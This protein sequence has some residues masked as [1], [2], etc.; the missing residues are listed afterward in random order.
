MLA[1]RGE[2]TERPSVWFS[3]VT[4][5]RLLLCTAWC[6]IRAAATI[7]AHTPHRMTLAIVILLCARAAMLLGMCAWHRSWCVGQGWAWIRDGSGRIKIWR[8]L[9][10]TVTFFSLGNL[11][12]NIAF[13]PFKTP[14][15]FAMTIGTVRDSPRFF[16][17]TLRGSVSEYFFCV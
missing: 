9:V 3:T 16:F 4:Y 14:A 8:W 7:L 13:P 10:V 2:D 15:L 5:V 6:V 1:T 17:S 11:L 12:G